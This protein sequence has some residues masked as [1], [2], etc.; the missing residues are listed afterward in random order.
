MRYDSDFA[1][2]YTAKVLASHAKRR[3]VKKKQTIVIADKHKDLFKKL[4]FKPSLRLLIKGKEPKRRE[5]NARRQPEKY[6]DLSFG[7]SNPNRVS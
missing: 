1:N 3:A 6:D 7:R 2:K 5:G 4:N